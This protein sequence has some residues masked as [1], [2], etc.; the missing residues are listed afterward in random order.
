MLEKIR[1][2]HPYLRFWFIAFSG[3]I[4]YSSPKDIAASISIISSLIWKK[5]K[6][7][8]FYYLK[9]DSLVKRFY[10]LENQGADKESLEEFKQFNERFKT[11]LY[12]VLIRRNK[13]STWFRQPLIDL[14]PLEKK[15]VQVKFSD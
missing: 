7:Y 6:Q 2:N 3:T 8:S 15:A 12:R 5:N 11:L 4:L 10:L 14:K 1:K 13:N 9:V